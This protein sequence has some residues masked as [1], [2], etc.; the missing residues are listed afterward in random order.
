MD[1]R[2][3]ILDKTLEI[4]RKVGFRAMTLDDLSSQLG[5]SKKTIYAFFADKEAIVDAV[6]DQEMSVTKAECLL[7]AT[8]A[9]NAID[10]IFIAMEFMSKDFSDMNPIVIHDLMKFYPSTFQ[11]FTEFKNDIFYT[12]ISDNLKKGIVEGYYRKDLNIDILT[13]LRLENILLSFDQKVFPVQEYNI[14]EV[15]EV[16]LSHFLYGIVT[17]KGFKLIQEYEKNKNI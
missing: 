15:T 9:K 16:I 6:M 3:R 2:Q 10:E 11:K 1:T 12:V 8:Q 4:C 17:E 5:I 14:V 13:K 7:H